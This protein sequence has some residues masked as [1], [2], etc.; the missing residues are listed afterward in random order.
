MVQRRP[1]RPLTRYQRTLRNRLR[2]VLS[3]YYRRPLNSIDH[4]PWEVMHHLLAYG[5]HGRILDGSRVRN[6]MTSVGFLCYNI[7]CQGKQLMTLTSDNVI[8]TRVDVGL[9]G[10]KGQFLAMLAQCDVSPRYPMRVDGVHLT[11]EDLIHSEQLSCYSGE[12]LTFKL[13]GLM[14]YL[15]PNE[16]WVN[17]QGETWSF[18]RLIREE[19]KQKIRGA[20]CGGVHRLSGLSLA[21][22]KRKEAGQPISGEYFESQLFL[23]EY[24]RYAYN[25]QNR[26]GSLSTEWFRGPGDNPDINRRVRTT[27]HLL[28]WLLYTIPDDMLSDP[29]TERAVSYLT[30]VLSSNSN[31]PWEIGPLSHALHALALYDQRV[32]QPHDEELI[33]I[34][35]RTGRLSQSPENLNYV[36]I[37]SRVVRSLPSADDAKRARRE[38]ANTSNNSLRRL[39]GGNRRRTS[40]S[41]ANS[42]S[43]QPR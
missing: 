21:I 4:D 23:E 30:N 10:H 41:P 24:V 15:R 39:F 32:F 26:D 42:S 8:E 28:E 43:R 16:T 14:H 17:D 31:N 18:P 3:Y 2:G 1:L 35:K 20:A 7:P 9:Q 29:R 36:N 22:A 33:A 19:R 40:Y 13:I 11:I 27:G 37:D 5:K 6:P 25:W 12:E 38:I 34:A